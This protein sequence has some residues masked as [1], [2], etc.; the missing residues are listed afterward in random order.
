MKCEAS[1]NE[2]CSQEVGDLF[3]MAL[4]GVRGCEGVS[5]VGK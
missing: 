1:R 3:K 5:R 4:D 2:I